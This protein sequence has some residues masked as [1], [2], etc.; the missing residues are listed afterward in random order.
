MPKFG[1]FGSDIPQHIPGSYR[2]SRCTPY[3]VSCTAFTSG[4]NPAKTCITPTVEGANRKLDG[5]FKYE[6][7]ASTQALPR[8]SY[9]PSAVSRPK[10]PVDMKIRDSTFS[11]ESPTWVPRP[12]PEDVHKLLEDFLQ[13]TILINHIHPHS[14]NSHPTHPLHTRSPLPAPLVKILLFL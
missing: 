5:V 7:G 8:T 13:N 4:R 11:D 1:S 12:P 3:E 10:K 14:F 2:A 6:P 9:R